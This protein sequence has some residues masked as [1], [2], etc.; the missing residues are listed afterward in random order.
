MT[1][2]KSLTIVTALLAGGTSL[3]MAQNGP[4]TGGQTTVAGRANGG[5]WARGWYAGSGYGYGYCIFV[6]RDREPLSGAVRFLAVCRSGW[7]ANQYLSRW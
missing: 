5:S 7:P 1:T 3:A 6:G 4:P 2:L